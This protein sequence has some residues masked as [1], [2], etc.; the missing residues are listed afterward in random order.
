ML[1]N[2]VLVTA[3]VAV[4]PYEG[5]AIVTSGNTKVEKY[6][7]TI[8]LCLTDFELAD[9]RQFLFLIAKQTNP[10]QSNRRSMVQ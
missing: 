5:A 8:D 9:N 3:T 7:C 4:P 6:H 2:I 10:N 1:I